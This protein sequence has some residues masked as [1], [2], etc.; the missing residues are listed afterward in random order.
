M[1]QENNPIIGYDEDNNPIR[2]PRGMVYTQAFIMCS[3]CNKPISSH[4]GP[5]YNSVCVECHNKENPK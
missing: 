3:K 5:R 1:V 4:G 2:Q